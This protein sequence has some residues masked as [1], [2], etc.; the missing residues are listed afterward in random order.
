[1]TTHI[2]KYT[3][4]LIGFFVAPHLISAETNE[5]T[6]SKHL[7][8]H[9]NLYHEITFD[10]PASKVWPHIINFGSYQ[11]DIGYRHASGPANQVGQIYELYFPI[12]PE[13]KQ[14]ETDAATTLKTIRMIPNE[15][16]HG[17]N[18][19][20][21]G[22]WGVATGSNIFIL[23]EFNGKTT[24]KFIMEKQFIFYNSSEEEVEKSMSHITDDANRRWRE[25]YLP[26][27]KKLVEG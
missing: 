15:L 24:A 4:L 8:A 19:I 11:T 12:V 17:V 22:S 27:L 13:D 9:P 26:N 7:K 5:P 23:E 6:E 2:A 1:M 16:W 25:I 21:A 18:L 3:F 10:K 14:D 20:S